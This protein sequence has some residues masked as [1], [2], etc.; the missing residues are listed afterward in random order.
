MIKVHVR[1][2]HV[3]DAVGIDPDHLQSFSHRAEQGALSLR[4]ARCVEAGI[5]HEASLLADDGPDKIVKR[6][7]A[8]V[9]IAAEKIVRCGSMM[10]AVA[11]CEQVVGVAHDGSSS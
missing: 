8:V 4:S 7:R 10:M 1:N 3:F 5:E 6:H 2:D 11:D 9:W